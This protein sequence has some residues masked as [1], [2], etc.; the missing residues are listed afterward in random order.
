MTT[1]TQL[2]NRALEPMRDAAKEFFDD[3]ELL[4]YINESIEDLCARERLFRKVGTIVTAGGGLAIP[5]D[6][7]QTRWAKSPD[8][9]EVSWMDE[10]TFFDYQRLQPDWPA[11]SPLA[12]IYNDTIW[13]HPE[14]ADGQNWEV[15]YNGLPAVMA[16]AGDTYPLRRIWER[17]TVAYMQYRMWGRLDEPGLSDRSHAEYLEGLRPAQGQTDHQVPGRVNLAREPNVF[18]DDPLSIHRGV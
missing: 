3:T 1:G 2:I 4:A 16:A 9:D 5:A 18:D 17:R 12:T 8:G 11:T 7:L 14:P 15:G 10:T 13:I 6:L